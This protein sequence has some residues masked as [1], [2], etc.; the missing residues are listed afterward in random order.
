MKMT[1]FRVLLSIRAAGNLHF[2]Q[3]MLIARY[4]GNRG[5][6][7]LGIGNQILGMIINRSI[8]RKYFRNSFH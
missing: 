5:S 6:K 3:V 4:E 8:W 1:T 7:D 2:E